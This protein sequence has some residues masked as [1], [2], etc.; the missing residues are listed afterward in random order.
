[1]CKEFEPRRRPRKSC[2]LGTNRIENLRGV[3]IDELLDEALKQ[4]FPESDP[5]AID[6]ERGSEHDARVRGSRAP[7]VDG[8]L[9]GLEDQV[10]RDA[11]AQQVGD[12]RS[13]Q[14]EDGKHRVG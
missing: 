3:H 1:M 13:K 6:I 12:R 9:G 11:G 10:P 5:V 2:L 7:L 14:M 4:T 8:P